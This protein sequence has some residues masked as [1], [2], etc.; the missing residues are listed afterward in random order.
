MISVVIPAYNEEAL[1][2]SCLESFVHQRTHFD[3]EIIL[4][5]NNS[6]DRTQEIATSYMARVPLRIVF[7]SRKGRG[8]ARK[9]GFAAARGEIIAST[10]ADARVPEHWI[11]TIGS[12]FARNPRLAAASSSS[13]IHDCSR[14][15]NTA[16]NALQ[17]V[18]LRAGAVIVGYQWLNGFNFAVRRRAYEQSGGFR[19][20]L[21]G[22]E[23]YD[24]ARRIGKIGPT[25]FVQDM[26]VIFSG[27]RFRNGLFVGVF[28]YCKSLA[29]YVM[30]HGDGFLDDVR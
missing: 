27:R 22:I 8:Q 6:T 29:R 11:E 3:F 17:P 30:P 5:D 1:I 23:D 12:V 18:V 14:F 9:T 20:D 16:Y 10:D 25:L 4:V 19:A 7:E 2:G 21:N 26:A 24:L 28:D 15:T 13:T